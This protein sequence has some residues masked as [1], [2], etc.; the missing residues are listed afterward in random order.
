MES[1]TSFG[2]RH[3][4]YRNFCRDALLVS[5]AMPT[6]YRILAE[7]LGGHKS[8]LSEITPNHHCT[9]TYFEHL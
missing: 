7:N 4:I 2:W 9:P 1:A 8:V 6:I 3:P 5:N